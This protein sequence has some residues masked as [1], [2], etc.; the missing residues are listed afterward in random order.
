MNS[1][2]DLFRLN[3][4]KGVKERKGVALTTGD[5][6]TSGSKPGLRVSPLAPRLPGSVILEKGMPNK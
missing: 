4:N 5:A 1:N 3:Y 6:P 2:S